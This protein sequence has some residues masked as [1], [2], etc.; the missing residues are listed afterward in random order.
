MG[1]L[2]LSLGL[3]SPAAAQTLVSSDL[4]GLWEPSGDYRGIDKAESYKLAIREDLSAEYIHR[5][6]SDAEPFE[7]TIMNKGIDTYVFVYHC[8]KQDQLF[9]VLALSGWQSRVGTRLYGQEYWAGWPDTGD[10]YGGVPVS[11][12]KSSE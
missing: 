2:V 5:T 8:Y 11:Y 9:M 12:E 3:I 7:C 4:P 1:F 10:I 6:S